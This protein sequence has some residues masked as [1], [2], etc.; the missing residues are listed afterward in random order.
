M[1]LSRQTRAR[2]RGLARSSIVSAA[3]LG[4]V[5]VVACGKYGVEDAPFAGDAGNGGDAA[6]A[7]GPVDAALPMDTA[8]DASTGDAD[9]SVSFDAAGTDAA[10]CNVR[11]DA[12]PVVLSE[13]VTEGTAIVYTSNPPSSGNHYDPWANFQEFTQPVADGYLV[14]AMEHGAVLLLYKCAS[15]GAACDALVA[16]LRAVRAAIPTDPM[17]DAAIRVRVIIA[18]RAANDTV[19]A[20]SAWGFTYRADC[21]DANSLTSFVNDHYAKAPENLC[22]AGQVL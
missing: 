7:I 5:A 4:F 22:F 20:A 14:H 21:V 15:P 12:I 3:A 9:S 19:V 1:T 16:S 10:A 8:L 17:C 13:H 18:P 2:C 11:V 6:D